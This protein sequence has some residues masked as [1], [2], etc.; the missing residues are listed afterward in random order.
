MSDARAFPPTVPPPPQR[1]RCTAAGQVA[2]GEATRAMGTLLHYAWCKVR[3]HVRHCYPW[4]ILCAYL[5][6]GMWS[7]HA[8]GGQVSAEMVSGHQAIVGTWVLSAPQYTVLEFLP[9]GTVVSRTARKE[10][11][12]T[13]E[14]SQSRIALHFPQEPVFWDPAIHALPDRFAISGSELSLFA[15]SGGTEIATAQVY[16][17]KRLKTAESEDLA[18]LT[19]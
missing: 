5:A 15:T 8:G 2:P 18:A 4:I 14:V 10:H 13:Y 16:R 3:D 12:G 7:Q 11:R 6:Y 9:D 1:G 17:F 19:R